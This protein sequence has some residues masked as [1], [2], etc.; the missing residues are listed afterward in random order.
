MLGLVTPMTYG[1]IADVM[2]EDEGIPTKLAI[3]ILAMLG[4]GV[5]VYT[6]RSNDNELKNI[7]LNPK[8]YDLG[9]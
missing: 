6:Q 8:D 9:Y 5:Q 2:V 3:S 1:D 7:G 4:E